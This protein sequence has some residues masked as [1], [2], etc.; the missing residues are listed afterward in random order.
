MGCAMGI[1]GS[2]MGNC[3]TVLLI[4]SLNE[5]D[6]PW[7]DYGNNNGTSCEHC[8]TSMEDEIKT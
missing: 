5:Y 8:G 3:E 1:L 4:S 2:I 6:T 7:N